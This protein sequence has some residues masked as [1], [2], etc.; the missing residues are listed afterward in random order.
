MPPLHDDRTSPTCPLLNAILKHADCPMIRCISLCNVRT[1]LELT[2]WDFET[3]KA[4]FVAFL[5]T[6]GVAMACIVEVIDSAPF[7][8]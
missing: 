3:L 2:T 5:E 1:N 8:S 7:G 4:A 6:N